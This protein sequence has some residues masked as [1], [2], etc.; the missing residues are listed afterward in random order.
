VDQEKKSQ[1]AKGTGKAKI[2]GKENLVRPQTS[3]KC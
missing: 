2:S 1:K 3:T